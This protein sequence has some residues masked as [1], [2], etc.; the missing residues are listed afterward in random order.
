MTADDYS[1][2][3][4]AGTAAHYKA[5]PS[6]RQI[7]LEM[8]TATIDNVRVH[9]ASPRHNRGRP[10]TE[11]EGVN[12]TVDINGCPWRLCKTPILCN[13]SPA[14]IRSFH[15]FGRCTPP[16]LAFLQVKGWSSRTFD[17]R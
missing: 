14:A 5:P 12:V 9:P 3:T 2:M 1:F 13:Y 4:I 17:D 15:C 16:N 10:A 11:P 7:P 8:L 6:R